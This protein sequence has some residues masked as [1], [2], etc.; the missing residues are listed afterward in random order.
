MDDLIIRNG[1]IFDGTGSEPFVGDVAISGETITAVGTVTSSGRR[2]IDA[3]GHIVTPGWVDMHTHYDAQATWDPELTPSGWHGV[4]TVV[5]G[6][7]GVGF[8]PVAPD[9]KDYLISV[10]E[11]VEDIPGAALAA[12]IAWEWET[13]PEYLDALEK[14]RWVCDLGTQVPHVALRTYVMGERGMSQEPATADDLR[15]MQELTKEALQAGALGISTSRTPLHKTSSGD[16]VPGTFAEADE[17]YA[18]ADAV[19]LAGHGVFQAALHHPEVPESFE[20]LREVAIRSGQ[21]V[22]FNFSQIDAAPDVWKSVLPLLDEAAQDDLPIFGQ[23]AGRAVGLL[24]SWDSSVHPFV[25]KPT[26]QRIAKLPESERLAELAKPEVRE[27]MLSEQPNGPVS[28]FNQFV[29]EGFHKMYPFTGETDYEPEPSASLAALAGGDRMLAAATAY[30]LMTAHNGRGLLYFPL[31]NYTGGNLDVLHTL[32]QHPQTRMGLGDAG[33]HC[34][35]ICDGGMPTFM[36]THWGRDR[37][38]GT[39]PL[40]LIVHRQTQQTAEHYG[41]FDR[42]VLAPGMRADINVIDFERLTVDAP[43]IAFDLPTNARRF[44]QHSVG[45]KATICRGV[46]VRENDCF[47]GETPGRLVRGPQRRSS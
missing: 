44:V 12:G 24:M 11:G 10:M 21:R 9:R 37:P 17:L 41:L 30:D 16:L 28:A 34:G 2:E 20:W 8:A 7:C 14:R 39:L 40:P 23:V 31:M 33:A 29:T 27:T 46:V 22:T 19:R 15:A 3:T 42:G 38:R 26:W 32:H 43:T 1:T 36:V 13:F 5:V 35:V 18:L 47:T 4:T 25:F 45:Y 6:N